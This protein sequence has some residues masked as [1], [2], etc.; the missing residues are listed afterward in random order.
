MAANALPLIDVDRLQIGMYVVLDLGWKN[1]P[2]LRS[3]FTIRSEEQLAQL[4]SLGVDQVRWSPERSESEPLAERADA[5]TPTP[6]PTPSPTAAPSPA[7]PA[8]APKLMEPVDLDEWESLSEHWLEDEYDG[9]AQQHVA[10]F[11][12]LREDPAAARGAAEALAESV[13]TAL[14][15]CDRPA[16]RLLTDK[17]AQEQG[18]HEVAVV[19]L[20]LLLG[21][22]AGLDDEALR[23]LSMA[24]LLHDMG[25]LHLPEALRACTGEMSPA[26]LESWR[27]HVERGVAMAAEMG[28]EDEAIRSIAEHHEHADGSGF[29]KGLRADQLS[30]PGKVLAIANRY[31][32]LVCPQHS[33]EGLTPT[34]RCSRCT[35]ASA[36]TS[37]P[38][39]WPASCD[40]SASIRQAPWWN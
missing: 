36:R 26:Q 25:K 18:S 13:A 27:S 39:S 4:R 38:R 21:R 30:E 7:P 15:E 1:H 31:M 33:E 6:A 24:A 5:P 32:D 37:M 34:R 23:H 35:A 20:S 3:R 17:A 29:P 2:F 12:A 9:V 40:C 10:L 16:V 11:S 22:D 28:L 19:A 14:S 8:V